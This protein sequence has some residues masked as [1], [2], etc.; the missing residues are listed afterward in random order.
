M[1]FLKNLKLEDNRAGD[2]QQNSR[3]LFDKIDKF[4][5]ALNG[6]SSHTAPQSTPPPAAQA[7]PQQSGGLLGKIGSA[8]AEHHSQSSSPPPAAP[9]T[10]PKHEGLLGKIGGVLGGENYTTSAPPPAAPKHEG[11]LGKVSSVLSSNTQQPVK[12]DE[13][14]L[15]KLGGVLTG[16]HQTQAPPKPQGL[17]GKINHVLGG[18]AAG[19]Q[20]EGKP[21]SRYQKQ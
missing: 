3:G 16:S 9:P 11:L 17:S 6:S 1:D 10:A 7:K 21:R 18:G 20:K 15:G 2:S 5:G 12:Q 4:A 13:S 14:L 8:I 19:E